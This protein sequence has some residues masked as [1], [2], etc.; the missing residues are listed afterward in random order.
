MDISVR[1]SRSA[2]NRC[3]AQK[4]RC[5]RQ[6]GQLH[7]ERCLK[8][9]TICQFARRAPR[10]SKKRQSAQTPEQPTVNPNV[11]M[12]PTR[13]DID[14]VLGLWP[15]Q[16]DSSDPL[17]LSNSDVFNQGVHFETTTEE[18]L[19]WSPDSLPLSNLIQ[20][21][22]IVAIRS[23]SPVTSIHEL[24]NLSIADATR[25]NTCNSREMMPFV[26]DELFRLTTGFIDIITQILS[27][28]LAD[29][30][31]TLMV[32]SCYS[33][34]LRI[35]TTIFSLVQRCIRHSPPPPRNPDWVIILPQVQMGSVLT[36][37]A[38]RVD[39]ETTVS[40]DKASMYMSMIVVFSWQLWARMT[41]TVK[42]HAAE[43]V[44]GS[45]I[46]P[47]IWT[48]M[49]NRMDCLLQTIESTKSLLP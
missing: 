13:T 46:V 5:V 42:G 16:D 7:C 39:A 22:E 37:P 25:Q 38:I 15:V 21:Q 35:Y 1:K 28:R 34:L 48:E 17:R 18:S 14:S 40:S 31:T 9:D 2:C 11:S 32:G 45:S 26:F 43:V 12:L 6:P 24:A 23:P 29:E 19:L 41:D 3:H 30:A 4:L 47:T 49:M 27:G 33:R 8:L 10:G 44:S 36:S 20:D